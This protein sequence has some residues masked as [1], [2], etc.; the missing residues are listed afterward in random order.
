MDMVISGEWMNLS[1]SCKASES[2]GENN[3]VMV[4]MKR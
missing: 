1:F 3:L 4:R 2:P